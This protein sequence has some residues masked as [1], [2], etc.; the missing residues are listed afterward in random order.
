MTQ[1]FSTLRLQLVCVEATYLF[2]FCPHCGFYYFSTGRAKTRVII[3][4]RASYKRIGLTVKLKKGANFSYRAR[5]FSL[6][7]CKIILSNV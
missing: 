7:L 4:I 5:V 2:S 1:I 3:F 6:L